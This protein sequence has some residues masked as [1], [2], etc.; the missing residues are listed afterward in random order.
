M[1]L[2]RIR[3]FVR[4]NQPDST[5]LPLDQCHGLVCAQDLF[6]LHST[7]S[8]PRSSVDGYALASA[9]TRAAAQDK[10][11]HLAVCGEIRPSTGAPDM[12]KEGQAARIL[13]GG[14]VPQGAD[15]VVADEDTLAAGGNI[16]VSREHRPGEHVR[17]AGSDLKAGSR[18]VRRGEDLNP[19]VLAALAVSGVYRA[20]AFTP[21]RTA[22]MAIGNEL[23]P[24]DAQP[25]PGRFPADNL[26]HVS[27]LLRQRGV[28]DVTT[29]VV[30]NDMG[31]IVERLNAAEGCRLII[32]TGGTGPGERDFILS[33]CKESGFTPL[34]VGLTLTPGKSVFVATRGSTLLFALPG[35]PWA[36]FALMHALVLPT[37]CWLRGRTLPVPVPVLAR[38]LTMPPTPQPEWERLT[39][40][41]VASHG[42]ELDVQPLLDRNVETR[43]DMLA[44]QGLLIVSSQAVDD[45]LLPMIP[46]WENRRGQRLV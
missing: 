5:L 44:A 8:E 22:V 19:Q 10:P 9:E 28:P 24:L 34:F 37:V 30:P 23:A 7:P 15:A 6:A 32:T 33:A 16:L 13:T 4:E 39:P 29:H 27:G 21:P 36:V 41:I 46:V 20:Q 42:A 11:A 38:P 25:E 12:L 26:L 14:K 31:S 45:D 43:L 17:A 1:A 2:E 40:C 3:G 18:I 35:T